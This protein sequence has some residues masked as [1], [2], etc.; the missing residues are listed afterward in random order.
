M[1]QEAPGDVRE[2]QMS[3][4]VLPER[5]RLAL[6]LDDPSQVL[7]II[8]T[9]RLVE[10]DGEQFVVVPHRLDEV[11]V[12]RNLGIGVPSPIKYHY[13]WVG[14]DTPFDAQR[15][16]AAF[17]TLYPRGYILLD[18]GTGKTRSVL[19]AFDYLHQHSAANKMLVVSPLSTLERVWGDEI[20]R[21]FVDYRFAVL[22]GT[23]KQR[24]D[25]LANRDFDI[26]IINHDGLKTR[27]FVEAMA[28]R[29]DINVCVI[30]EL[31]AFRNSGTDKW[32]AL[33]TVVNKQCPRMVWGMTGTPMPNEPTDAWAQCRLITPDTITPYFGKFRDMT[34][35]KVTTYK[36]VAKPDAVDI[37]AGMMQPAIRYRRDECVDLPPVMFEARDVALTA[38]QQKAYSQMMLKLRTEVDGGQITA[39]NE[40][41]KMSRLVQIACGVVYDTE[42]EGRVIPALPRLEVTH[43]IIAEAAAKTIVFVPFVSALEN[44]SDYLRSKGV[45]TAIIHGQIPKNRRDEIFK[46]FQQQKDPH[47]IVAQPGTMSHG[48]TLTAANTIIW[49]APIHSN[50]TFQQADARVSRPGQ[51]FNQLIVMIS[52]TEVER[53]IY[54]KLQRR[55][56]LQGT[57]LS[58]IKEQT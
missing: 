16:T 45:T 7:G 21:H 42:G 48:L 5:R 47:V 25:L 10:Q 28:K 20:F 29:P 22:H 46:E 40:G 14:T 12:L 52:G 31:A 35:R 9:A 34:M 54:S 26:Y 17:A 18:M 15:E 41:V 36:W 49:F 3:M 56:S 53:R 38:E 6:R 37:V 32:E 39:A 13:E 30:D 19:W 50:E 1:A 33:N 44:V 11:R 4:I 51:K 43:E 57:L 55:E 24:L 27:G 2:A 58:L 8:P 23:R